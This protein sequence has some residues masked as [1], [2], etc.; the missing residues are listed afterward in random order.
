MCFVNKISKIFKYVWAYHDEEWTTGF[1]NVKDN[2]PWKRDC[3]SLFKRKIRGELE[4]MWRQ[5]LKE[6]S[7]PA[8]QDPGREMG[9]SIF[10]LCIA[11]T[12]VLVNSVNGRLIQLYAEGIDS[13][14][15]NYTTMISLLRLCPK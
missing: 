15:S 6:F 12:A 7:N 3:K 9:R 5:Y 2:K 1:D 13:N 11:D 4:T 10:P 14:D 8:K